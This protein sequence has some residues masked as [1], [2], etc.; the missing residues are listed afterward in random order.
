L[1]SLDG[2]YIFNTYE[3]SDKVG[4]HGYRSASHSA[5]LKS[6]NM[7]TRGM[8][9]VLRRHPSRPA[10][11][12]PAN[13]GLNPKILTGYVIECMVKNDNMRFEVACFVEFTSLWK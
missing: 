2:K 13:P 6:F 5:A 8:G 12:H 9:L 7:Y 11:A 3:T 10:V 1:D 4:Y